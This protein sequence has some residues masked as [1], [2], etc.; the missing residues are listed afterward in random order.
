MKDISGFAEAEMNA[1]MID[2]KIE[3]GLRGFSKPYEST[4]LSYQNEEKSIMSLVDAVNK[5]SSISRRFYKLHARLL[6]L[7]QL[8]YADSMAEIGKLSKRFTLAEG[9]AIL[10]EAL[11]K[12]DPRYAQ[13]FSDM[14]DN[15]QIDFLPRKGKRERRVLLER[16][17]SADIHP[18]QLQ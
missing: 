3:D 15:G 14:V 11:E 17:R 6:K 12:Y 18:H 4:L 1:I 8:E 13:I 2:K 7:K 10:K 5:N 9:I 16:E